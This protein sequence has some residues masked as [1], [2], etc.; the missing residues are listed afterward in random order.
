VDRPFHPT[1]IP[2]TGDQVSKLILGCMSYGS[3]QPDWMIKDHDEAIKQIK[4]AYD[5]GINVR[6]P[7]A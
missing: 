4:Y 6:L 5:Q 2:L 3:G 7:G 1:N